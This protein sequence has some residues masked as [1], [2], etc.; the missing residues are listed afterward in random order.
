M[1]G[2]FCVILMMIT[3]ALAY[4]QNK[5][6][7][8][9]IMAD[10]LGYGDVGFNGNTIIKTP[11]MD[12]LANQHLKLSNFYAGAPV[13]SPTRGT[14]LTG[15]HAY[16][17]GIFAANE[18]HLPA[19][20]VTLAKIL[21][22][23]GYATGHFGKWHIGTLDPNYSSKGED[24]DPAA[25]FAPPWQRD[26]DVSFV[27]ESSVSTW[28]PT[29]TKVPYYFN[30]Q[31]TTDNLLGDDSRVMMDRIIP[32]IED[33]VENTTPFLSVVWFHAPHEPFV[34]GPTYKAM[35]EGYSEDEKDYY[36][37]ITA[38][39]EQIGRLYDKLEELS[40]DD[41]TII[42]FCSD[43]G[44]E[45]KEL[46]DGT[47][48]KPG[49]TGGL[50]GRKR[51]VYCGGTGVPA[52]IVW[53]GKTDTPAVSDYTCSTL[54]YLPTIIDALD[55]N[56]PDDRPIDGISLLPMLDGLESERPKALPFMHS[57]KAFWIDGDLKF[58][59]KNN[60][61]VNEVY[62]LRDDRAEETNL[63][64]DYASEMAQIQKDIVAWSNSCAHSHAGGDYNEAFT[65]VD[66]WK[67]VPIATNLF[68]PQ[69]F[70]ASIYP[71]PASYYISLK[72]M[73]DIKQVK[74][75]NSIGSLV[76][77]IE[78]PAQKINV[79]SL[80]NGLYILK[81]INNKGETWVDSFLIE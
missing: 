1:K 21:K 38:M 7:I 31:I 2:I 39:D 73:T 47:L 70:K 64:S 10:D 13:C 40:I 18:G 54:D 62:N 80:R 63:K 5:P 59:T 28:N 34:A 72:N 22:Q 32:F 66:A 77:T 60:W 67:G 26:Y 55:I 44:P 4:A 58:I 12:A 61:D 23:N 51:S 43:N 20:E 69:V 37:C 42:F 75:F 74:I 45:G 8:I 41:N 48:T 78:Q 14:C 79:A 65:P 16:R 24:R 36:G 3:C 71:N 6:N 46:D 56:M 25:N 33:A 52:F 53:P 29:S 15:R 19:Q 11:E 17:Y 57:S 49:V 68:V 76:K 50:R 9:L 81:A 35:Y 27:T 30:G